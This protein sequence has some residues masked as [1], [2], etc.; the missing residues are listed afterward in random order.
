MESFPYKTMIFDC[1]GVLLDSNSAKSDAFYKVALPYGD[2]CAR[3]LLNF[4]KKNGGISRNKKFDYFVNI[5]NFSSDGI[6]ARVDD[7]ENDRYRND[8]Y[9]GNFGYQRHSQPENGLFSVVL[10][11]IAMLRPLCEPLC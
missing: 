6:S 5:T 3:E 2:N 4:H 8:N 1:D 11:F 10:Y 7:D 9:E